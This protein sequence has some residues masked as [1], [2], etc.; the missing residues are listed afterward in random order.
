MR[1]NTLKLFA[2]YERERRSKD[3]KEDKERWDPRF[4]FLSCIMF[5]RKRKEKDEA[6]EEQKK[7]VKKE[8]DKQWEVLNISYRH[9][10][11]NRI[12]QQGRDVRVNS[13]QNFKTVGGKKSS[14]YAKVPK[15][16]T[17]KRTEPLKPPAT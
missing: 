17:E 8:T 2:N 9:F 5:S 14:S 15:L 4:N 1:K 3:E 13:W 16:K 10:D 12:F 7:K 6:E 11:A